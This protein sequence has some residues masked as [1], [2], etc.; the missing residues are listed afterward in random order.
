MKGC[1]G[2]RPKESLKL[3]ILRKRDWPE[4]W[5]QDSM[6]GDL[7]LLSN[8]VGSCG[9]LLRVRHPGVFVTLSPKQVWAQEMV[10]WPIADEQ[11]LRFKIVGQMAEF[12]LR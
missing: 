12:F 5:T 9:A 1:G 7:L 8:S 6:V 3:N 10:E 2:C 4:S 11:I